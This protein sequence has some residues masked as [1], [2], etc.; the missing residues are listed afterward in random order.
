MVLVHF[1]GEVTGG[2]HSSWEEGARAWP[3]RRAPVRPC[4][5]SVGERGAARVGSRAPHPA[6]PGGEEDVYFSSH[7]LGSI[8][9]LNTRASCLWGPPWSLLSAQPVLALG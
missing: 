7:V 4:G 8:R 2:E 5:R 1:L 9:V 3:C 6:F